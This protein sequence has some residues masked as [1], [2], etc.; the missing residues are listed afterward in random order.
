[1]NRNRL[2]LLISAAMLVIMLCPMLCFAT[3]DEAEYV[4]AL[5]AKWW[6]VIPPL[7]A[8]ALALITKEVYS[9]L[10]IGVVI[11]GVLYAGGNF[12]MTMNHV[13]Q[14]GIVGSLSDAYNVG[15][16]IF[17]VI[18]GV[19]VALLNRTGG[20][21]AFGKWA[22][23]RVKTQTGVQLMTIIL[24]ILV[25]IDDYFNCLTVGSVMSPIAEAQGLP[26]TKL[27]YLIDSTA[28]PVCIIAPIS[29]WAA[30]VTGFVD[31]ENGFALFIKAIP[32]NFYAILTIVM[33]FTLVA[34]KFDYGTM[35]K[36]ADKL[37]DDTTDTQSSDLETTVAVNRRREGGVIDLVLPVIILIIAC[38]LGMIYSGG[39][40]SG[41]GFVEAF[42]NTA[43]SVLE[44]D[45]S[46]DH[47]D[48]NC[49]Y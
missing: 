35:K 33:M 9:S 24:G 3:G 4:P 38:V 41:A 40:F 15:I 46:S 36:Y 43:H 1:M 47:I 14:D 30:A 19:I 45:N 18:L 2:I 16:L 32:F 31:G 23:K 10:F 42:R 34:L 13:L 48:Y 8:I 12:E 29:S 39:F 25:F 22:I 17:L 28:A 6:S 20:A 5:Y 7:V 44:T 26:R 11:G 37:L 27:A 49:D 21:A